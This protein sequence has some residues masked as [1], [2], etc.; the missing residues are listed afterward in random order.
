MPEIPIILRLKKQR[1]KDVALAQ[2][3]L[4]K[5]IFSVFEDAV[6]HGGTGIWRCYNGTRFSE[7]IDVYIPHDIKRLDLLFEKLQNI[8]F[9]IEKRKE[10]EKGLYSALIKDRTIVRFEAS[11]R[12]IKGIIKEYE[13]C[14]GN[15][16][17]VITLSPEEL[18]KEKISAYQ[19][20]L[21]IRDLY[22]LF[23]LLRLVKDKTFFKKELEEFVKNFKNPIDENNLK[24][25][26]LESVVP[27][28]G[29]MLEYI[30]GVI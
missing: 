22:D 20:R 16:I 11:F 13:K 15:F 30:K 2:D 10:S 14:T 17:T 7:D 19:N 8:G 1:Q 29:Q 28:I 27:S 6:L 5:E 26:V 23:F 3:I 21:K 4:V 25:I 12:K 18:V 24:E 9:K